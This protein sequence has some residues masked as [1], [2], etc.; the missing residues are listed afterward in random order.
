MDRDTFR[1]NY[2]RLYPGP[3]P[4]IEQL[5]SI[6]E[7]PASDYEPGV[8]EWALEW[9]GE[10]GVSME[11]PLRRTRPALRAVA[12]QVRQRLQ[13]A[14]SD[15]T[16]RAGS[17]RRAAAARHS[18]QS[19]YKFAKGL[20]RL[21][22]FGLLWA[23]A[24]LR[25]AFAIG[26]TDSRPLPGGVQSFVLAGAF[27]AAV[28]WFVVLLPLAHL[29]FSGKWGGWPFRL[30]REWKHPPR[31]LLLRPFH[32]KQLSRRLAKAIAASLGDLGHVFTL[33]DENIKGRRFLWLMWIPFAVCLL[34][35]A[36]VLSSA[37][38]NDTPRP[39]VVAL[40]CVAV[41][42]FAQWFAWSIAGLKHY[43]SPPIRRVEDVPRCV[44]WMD[45]DEGRT[46]QWCFI[47]SK[48]FAMRC[49]GDIDVWLPTVAA[50]VDQVDIIAIDLSASG[51]RKHLELEVDECD[52]LGAMNRVMFLCDE[53]SEDDVRAYLGARYPDVPRR[54][55][56]YGGK[57]DGELMLR[58]C[59]L[60][61][62]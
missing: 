12:K 43:S 4:L 38:P 23:I 37:M 54:V 15:R 52:R 51:N 46:R 19:A 58:G 17:L 45:D 39:A 3:R 6:L 53:D 42:I 20:R 32:H 48:V 41:I 44:K 60:L 2:G 57:A 61:A 28:G 55:V 47:P 1:Q 10:L 11:V 34:A 8:Q 13:E 62:S 25:D 18:R 36:A 30:S 16:E 50:L 49:V 56:V 7:A 21:F 26:W 35:L 9:L 27:G 59:E 31:V 29:L 24:L 22:L 14:N 5:A 33:A 40:G